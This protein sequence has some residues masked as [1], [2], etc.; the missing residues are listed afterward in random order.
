MSRDGKHP[1]HYPGPGEYPAQTQLGQGRAGM[2]HQMGPQPISEHL[3]AKSGLEEYKGAE[4]LKDKIAVVTGGDSGIGRAV[5]VLF[6]KEGC[7]L[8]A[9][10]HLPEE[11]KDAQE[12]RKMVEK[13][14]AK[15][16][17]IPADI[18]KG[19]GECKRIVDKVVGTSEANG[20][21]N[22]FV[23]NA[24]V[25]FMTDSITD[26]K[27]DQIEL[28]FRTNILAMF[29]LTK[30]AVQ[31]MKEGDSI[32]NTTSVTAYKGSPSLLDYSSTKG[33]IVG[34]TRSLAKQLAPKGIRVNAVA[35]GPIWTPLQPVSRDE[36]NIKKWT[37]SGAP[38]LG[39]IGQP[40][41]V[42]TSYVFLASADG[43]YFAGQVLHPNGGDVVNG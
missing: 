34:F 19:E 8:V 35:P 9:I 23:N 27:S 39:R 29:W 30:H 4:K 24:A 2:Q 41:E 21:I 31:H 37:E 25:Q 18:S 12:A 7:K 42:A 3:P 20:R 11:E 33:A 36:E 22:I 16:L 1:D 43:A 28:T 17:L 26:L 38:P 5:A 14:G 10:V 40:A 32:I 6:A 15:C 13:E